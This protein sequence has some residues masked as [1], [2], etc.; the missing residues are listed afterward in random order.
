VL[1]VEVSQPFAL[2]VYFSLQPKLQHVIIAKERIFLYVRVIFH[3]GPVTSL[4][5]PGVFSGV[6]LCWSRMFLLSMPGNDSN[7]SRSGQTGLE[8]ASNY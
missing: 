7:L 2:S 3:S 1:C 4:F 8:I 6:F 5:H